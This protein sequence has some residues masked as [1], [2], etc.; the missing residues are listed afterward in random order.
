MSPSY[1][2]VT[3]GLTYIAHYSRFLALNI[4]MTMYLF[5]GHQLLLNVKLACITI[6]YMASKILYK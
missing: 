3:L 1:K 6:D 4:A 2:L 5:P